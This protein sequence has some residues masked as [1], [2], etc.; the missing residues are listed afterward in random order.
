MQTLVGESKRYLSVD[1]TRGAWKAETFRDEDLRD[2]L[3][4]KG[5]G[6]KLYLDRLDRRLE[7]VDPL[8]P[9]NLLLFMTGVFLGMNAPCSGRFSAVSRSPLTGIMAGSSCGGPFGLALRSAG[10]EG[11]LLGGA[12]AAPTVLR[13]DAD[14]VRF[15]DGGG[16]WGLETGPAQ[17][18]L[19]GG[20]GEAALVIGPAGENLVRFANIRAGHRFFGRAGLGAVMGSKR[21][22]AVVA[23]GRAFRLEPADPAAFRRANERA[24]RYIVRNAFSRRFKAYGTA[25][26]V[27]PGLEAGYVPALNFRGR[28]DGRSR[29]VSGEAMAER[30]HTRPATCRPCTVVCGHKGTWPDGSGRHVP[31]YETVALW[32]ANLGH[33]DPD[34]VSDWNERMNALGL[35]TISAGGTFAWAMEAAEKG[36]R[37][38]ALAFGRGDNLSALLEDTALRRGE[39]AELAEGSRRLA[40]R[41]GGLDFAIQ[42]KG[43][44]IAAYDPRAAW[45]H[46][47]GYAV[48][49]RGG[50]HLN[51]FLVGQEVLGRLLPPHTTRSKASWVAFMEDFFD[52]MNCT[53]TCLFTGFGLLLE[54]PA[55]RLTP[56][57]LLRLLMT[58]APGLAQ[59]ALD[60]SPLSRLV[61]AITGRPI[62]QRQYLRVGRRTHVLERWMNTR[63]GVRA[64][65]DTL[66]ARFLREPGEGQP[67]GGVVP[68]EPMLR[69]YYRKKGYDDDG[70]PAPELLAR[71]GILPDPRLATPA[72]LRRWLRPRG[73]PFARLYLSAALGLVGR[74]FVLANRLDPD[75]RRELAALPAGFTFALGVHPRGPAVALRRAAGG[76]LSRLGSCPREPHLLMRFANPAAALRVLTFRIGSFELY[77]R[78]GLAV[79][80]DLAATM[81]VMRA[82]GVVE[83]LLLPGFIARRVL[84]RLPG[85][86]RGRKTRERLLLLLG[87]PFAGLFRAAGGRAAGGRTLQGA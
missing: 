43:L 83:T 11:L 21:L 17:D 63:L 7:E 49:N 79:S 70:V 85:M 59:L 15:E 80:G 40:W 32:S 62:S 12:A 14:G 33:F 77:A 81:A 87:L 10:W 64:V 72:P 9:E 50:C 20:A 55:A 34:R 46:G 28:A 67:R 3:G 45:G 22:K 37:P 53:H 48:A 69:A 54:A 19:V 71:L 13:V 66:P 2:Y 26:N 52:A 76:G 31:E 56:L 74:A 30:Y 41:Y 25:G 58:W 75:V 29:A 82:L 8:G 39:G 61:S 51:A 36:L 38:S 78:G 73:R 5:L 57:P 44:E 23:A 1:L 42:A 35:D 65:D 4:G 86:P 60:W 18:R 68:L 6:L 24:Q 16:L 84:K 47:L 27:L